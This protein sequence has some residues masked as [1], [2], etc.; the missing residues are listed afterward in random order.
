MLLTCACSSPSND[1]CADCGTSEP[2]DAATHD[3]STD[4]AVLSDAGTDAAQLSDASP[5]A[6]AQEDSSSALDAEAPDGEPAYSECTL[7]SDCVL[8]PELLT[9]QRCQDGSSA[10]P[11]VRCISSL[12]AILTPR[13][14]A[15]AMPSSCTT[16]LD[17][18]RPACELRCQGDGRSACLPPLCIEGGCVPCYGTCGL[19]L[20]PCPTGSKPG[21]ECAECTPAGQCAFRVLGCFD[22]CAG[23][24][25]CAEGQECSGGLC[26]L[27]PHCTPQ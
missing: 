1:P 4:A 12:C 21:Q 26:Q 24:A 7:A 18:P 13:P 17:C 2:S 10:C 9:C 8:P 3:A 15:E 11:E 6:G 27:I 23:V 25:D 22:A 5:D 14:C 19:Q 16:D 20:E